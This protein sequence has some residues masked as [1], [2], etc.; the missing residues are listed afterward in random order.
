M[1]LGNLIEK[2][3]DI[4]YTKPEQW[5][6]KGIDEKA[7]TVTVYTNVAVVD[8]GGE[9][10]NPEQFDLTNYRK[11]PVFLAD[12][13]YILD[14]VL[15][16]C[17][18]MGV[19][20][21]GLWQTFEYFVDYEG[22]KGELA[23]WAFYLASKKVGAFSI[24][25]IPHSRKMLDDGTVSLENV[26]L[27]ETSQVVV[28]MNQEAVLNAIKG[29]KGRVPQ[30]VLENIKTVVPYK[31][32][33]IAPADYQWDANKERTAAT[34]DDLKVMAAWYDGANADVKSS[35]KLLHHRASDHKTVP[36]A[37]HAA[38]AALNGARGGVDIPDADRERVYN[39]LVKE[40]KA[41]G[42]EAP[43]LKSIEEYN[44]IKE[45]S[46]MYDEIVKRLEEVEKKLKEHEEILAKAEKF[47]QDQ[48]EINKRLSVN[49]T[50]VEKETE[51]IWEK[52]IETLKKGE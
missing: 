31:D 16:R 41:M 34:V 6:V 8:R 10:I 21:H 20:S 35:Y 38:M 4:M 12:H 39:H 1:E 3:S 17:I 47:A 36:N 52:V 45:E 11:N 51:D 28:P 7:H 46:K 14:Q 43:D 19:D 26:E 32:F 33:G 23:R 44:K 50:I 40:Y 29:Y 42:E 13:W 24:G 49:S 5:K 30:V 27:L 18:D 2:K 25:F 37:V 22:E 9:I 15:G 48:I